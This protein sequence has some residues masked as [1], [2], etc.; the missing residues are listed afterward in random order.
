MVWFGL[1]FWGS[2]L[3][4][5][6]G[7]LGLLTNNPDLSYLFF[8]LGLILGLTAKFRGT[9]LW[10][11]A[12]QTSIPLQMKKKLLVLIVAYNHEKFI[13]SVLDRINDN[14]FKTYEVEV[15]INDDSSSDNTLNVTKDYIKNNTDKKIKY[16]VLSNP[17]NQGYG[18]NQKIGFLYAIKNNFDFVALVHGDGQYA[19]EYLET[20]VEPLNDEN[21]DV[22]FGSRMINKD[23]AIKGGMPFYKYIGNKIL[24]FYQNKLFNKNFTEF[25]SGYR[26]YK[27]QSLKKIPYELI[28]FSTMF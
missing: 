28:S 27:V 24:T 10:I 26:I 7:E 15:L 4:A 22:V 21:T 20:L 12:K 14:L 18:G 8:L 11:P 17:V 6:A 5:F 3:N 2:V 25:H 19:P 23:G 1:I 9:W 13:K 16:T